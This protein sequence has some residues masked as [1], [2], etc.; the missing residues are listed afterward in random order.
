MDGFWVG[1][2]MGR[3]RSVGDVP[4]CDW[5]FDETRLACL[6]A[7]RDIMER[8]STCGDPEMVGGV[9]MSCMAVVIGGSWI[10]HESQQ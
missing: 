6:P 9:L 2:L 4:W 5:R 10:L 8:Y 3:V 1:E 7:A